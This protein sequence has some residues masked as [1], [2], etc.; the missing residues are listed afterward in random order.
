MRIA[1][2][3]PM[4]RA[5]ARMR[6][7][8][9]APFRTRTWF[10]IGFAAWLASIFEGSGGSAG[11]KF[12]AEDGSIS[13]M[14]ESA[15]NFFQTLSLSLLVVVLVILAVFVLFAL[16][17]I[18]SRMKF[19]FLDQ[20]VTGAAR[21]KEPWARYATQ[22]DSLFIWRV[23]FSILMFFVAGMLVL[24]LVVSTGVAAGVGWNEISI[25]AI[26]WCGSG[27]LFLVLIPALY[28]SLFLDSFVVP[29]MYRHGLSV[30]DAWRR[31]LPLLRRHA[32]HFL[33][34]GVVFFVLNVVATGVIV[35]AGVLTCCVG[36]ALFSLPYL[37]TVIT[38]PV[39]I[40]FRGYSLEYLAQFGEEYRALPPLAPTP[41]TAPLPPPPTPPTE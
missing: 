39:W 17:W 32:G 20:V 28:V 23:F 40:A 22:G 12:Q 33:L 13:E 27:L 26:V 2:V 6:A 15:L 35:A 3:E 9:F 21:V 19:V 11:S 38:L 24:A 41:P 4:A 36:L 18:S 10:V 8:L 16:L 1:Y 37:G 31:L 5:F 7:L 34:F 30:M 14:G 29:L 25:A